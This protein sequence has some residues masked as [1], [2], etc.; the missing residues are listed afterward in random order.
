MRLI[1]ITD[2]HLHADKQARSRAAIPWQQFEAVLAAVVAERRVFDGRNVLE[3]EAWVDRGFT[4][5]RIGREIMAQP[6][7]F[8]WQVFDQRG[9]AL[10]RDE[11]RIRQVTKASGSTLEELAQRMGGDGTRVAWLISASMSFRCA[12]VAGSLALGRAEAISWAN[13]SSATR[14]T[15]ASTSSKAASTSVR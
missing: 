8:A 9:I 4:Y 15:S 11:Y 6:N 12:T 5:A 3:A 14:A 7:M 13:P 2:A 1:Q 10:L